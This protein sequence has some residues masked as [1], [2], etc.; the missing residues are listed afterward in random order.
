[1]YLGT[2]DNFWAALIL[3]AKLLEEIHSIS[4]F[5]DLVI[6]NLDFESHVLPSNVDEV[7][8]YLTL[9]HRTLLDL[10]RLFK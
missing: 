2:F 8:P 4:R 9:V 6:L 7:G 3:N 1:M 5:L 10:P